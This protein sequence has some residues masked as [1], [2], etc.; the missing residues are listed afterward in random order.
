MKI[1]FIAGTSGLVGMQVLHQLLQNPSYDVVLSVG[2]RTLSLKH[3][4]LVQ[5]EGDMLKIASWD[6]ASKLTAGD[7][8]GNNQQLAISIKEQTAEIHGFCTLGTTIKQ[9][10]SKEKFY[11]VDHE[12]V[13]AFANW[14]K[15]L[16]A[17]K[18]LYVS[19]GGAD[20]TSS[21]YYMKV[22]GEVERDLKKIGFDYLG[23]L[24]P[25]LLM[26]NR[27]EFRLSESIT[28]ILMYPLVWLKLFKNFRPIHD[29]QV[30]KAMVKVAMDQR[31]N[32]FEIITSGE[33]QDLSK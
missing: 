29:Y 25:S 16:G 6:I 23:I 30:A 32:S 22:K 19:S 4:K 31:P 17:S 20:E 15:S 7:L 2:R 21:F 9:A 28:Q 3:A 1:A 27:S 24:R 18:F 8:G 10:G 5:I 13:L 12:M 11:A 14:A 26:G 33:Q